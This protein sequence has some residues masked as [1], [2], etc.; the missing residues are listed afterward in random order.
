LQLAQT[1]SEKWG[2]DFVGPII[3]LVSKDGQ[4]GITTLVVT[5]YVT[6]W[7]EVQVNRMDTAKVVAQFLYENI[8]TFFG[9]PLELM[10][11]C[12]THL[13]NAIIEQLTTKYLIKL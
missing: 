3:V 7:V 13:P 11:D 4:M 5:K 1:P 2:I 6:K 9:C 12:G 10:N 8:I